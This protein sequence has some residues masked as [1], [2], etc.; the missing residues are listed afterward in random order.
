VGDHRGVSLRATHEKV[1]IYIVVLA[2]TSDQLARLLAIRVFT[3]SYG[4]LHIGLGQT[5]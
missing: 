2:S 5:L 3:I 1:Y 4:L